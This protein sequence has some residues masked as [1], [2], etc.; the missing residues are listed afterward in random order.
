MLKF[1]CATMILFLTQELAGTPMTV[2]AKKHF[3]KDPF[4]PF[5]FTI[6]LIGFTDLDALD[7]IFGALEG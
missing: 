5:P 4:F 3:K 1:I 6:P 2:Q 7:M